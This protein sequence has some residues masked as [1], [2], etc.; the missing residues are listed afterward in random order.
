MKLNKF[1]SIDECQNEETLYKK[2]DTFVEEGKIE[3]EMIDKW[4]LKIKDLDL[5]TNEEK[6]LVDLFDSLELHSVDLEDDELEDD[7]YFGNDDELEDGFKT[8]R[9]KSSYEDFDNDF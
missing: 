4:T 5:S 9:G 6:N 2:L 7:L 8:R 1:Y 3:Y